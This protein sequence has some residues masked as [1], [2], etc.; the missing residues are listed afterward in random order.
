MG[1]QNK[2]NWPN[3]YLRSECFCSTKFSVEQNVWQEEEKL[4]ENKTRAPLFAVSTIHHRTSGVSC[5][6]KS[7]VAR[8][9]SSCPRIF[10]DRPCRNK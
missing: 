10:S 6:S 1:L 3:K 7:I 4:S 5:I 2:Q 9:F 8:A